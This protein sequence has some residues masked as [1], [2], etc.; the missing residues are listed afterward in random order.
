MPG[1]NTEWYVVGAAAGRCPLASLPITLFA[2][3]DC[4]PGSLA[5]IADNPNGTSLLSYFKLPP[6]ACAVWK[7]KPAVLFRFGFLV[8]PFSPPRIP[9]LNPTFQPG[10]ARDKYF[11]YYFRLLFVPSL[12]RVILSL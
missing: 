3:P 9:I 10:F 1:L 12:S 2:F 7:R 11:L 4:L 6:Y 5:L 8:S